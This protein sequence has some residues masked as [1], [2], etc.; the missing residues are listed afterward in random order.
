MRARIARILELEDLRKS[1]AD[2]LEKKTQE[3]DEMK[4]KN[5]KDALT[6]LWNRAYTEEKVNAMLSEGMKGAL[7]MMDMDNF[8]AINDTYGHQAGDELI[9]KAC[10]M[11]CKLFKHS[12]VFRIGGDEFLII[13]QNEEMEKCEEYIQK[14]KED[15]QKLMRN[16]SLTDCLCMTSTPRSLFSRTDAVFSG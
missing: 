8:K 14:V 11:I 2:R 4:S 5:S 15:M 16:K 12:P 7:F 9:K 3:V 6:G 10:T 13:V 1:L